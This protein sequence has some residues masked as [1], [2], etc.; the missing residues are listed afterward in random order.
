MATIALESNPEHKYLRLIVTGDLRPGEMSQFTQ[1]NLQIRQPLVLWDLENASWNIMSASQLLSLLDTA[2]QLDLPGH[3]TAFLFLSD[4]D[5]GMGRVWQSYTEV[6][7]FQTRYQAFK[8]RNQAL[9]WLFQSSEEA[10]RA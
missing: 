5:F 4:V 6:Q 1:Q 2:R 7:R 3:K 10:L 8:D 9:K